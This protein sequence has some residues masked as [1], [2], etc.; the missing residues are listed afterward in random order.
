MTESRRL[1][2]IELSLIRRVLHSAPP[3][4]INLALGELGFPLP[5]ILRQ[6]ALDLLAQ[7]TLVYTPNAGIPELRAAIAAIYPGCD[8][9]SV[10][11]CNGV[12]EAVFVTLLAILDPGDRVAIPDPDYP[13][14]SAICKMLEANVIRLPFESNLLSVDWH[15]WEQ[16]LADG[17]KTLVFSHPSNP[18]GHVFTEQEARRLAGLCSQHGI[19]L[20][21]DEIYSRLFFN[22]PP[23][24]FHGRMEPSFILGGLSKSH[25]MS[26]WRL[27]WIVAPPGFSAA[28]IKA[29][30]YVSTCSNWLSQHLAAYA[31]SDDGGRAADE[32]MG[33]L[34]ASR[35]LA[36][37]K[38]SPWLDRV[39]VPSATPYLLLRVEG[40]DLRTASY[41]ARK[42]VICVPGSA[43]GEVSRGWLRINYAVDKQQLTTALD[44]IHD[45]LYLH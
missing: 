24:G 26:G 3:G 43:F 45:E 4:A 39:L 23:P 15:K 7:G 2:P 38:L 41:L 34:Q 31:L 27:G 11:V 44:I 6:K 30:Q 5:E 22:A 1:Q 42:G 28:V 20:V 19:V 13:A 35:D 9:D 36:L 18:C 14:Y 17:V 33:Q 29:R 8:P 37:E 40:D 12:E 21:V 10:C 32:V 16:L 25:C